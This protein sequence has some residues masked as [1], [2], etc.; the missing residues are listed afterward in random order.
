MS[1]GFRLTLTC[2]A[3]IAMLAAGCNKAPPPAPTMT[4]ARPA[5]WDGFVH[6]FVEG[7]LKANP[8]QGVDAGRHEE[9][10]IR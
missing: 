10:A 4:E 8:F 3:L 6:R 5:Q 1:Y 2:V 7:S 9:D